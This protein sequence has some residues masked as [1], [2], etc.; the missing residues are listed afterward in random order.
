M[1]ATVRKKREARKKRLL[2]P[3]DGESGDGCPIGR[4]HA[5][6]MMTASN[7]HS[8]LG[9]RVQGLAPAVSAPCFSWHVGPA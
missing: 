4:G 1:S 8:K 6:S 3:P 5:G 7:I 9:D 2:Q